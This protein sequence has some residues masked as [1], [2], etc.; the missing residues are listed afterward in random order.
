[1]GIRNFSKTL[2]FVRSNAARDATPSMFHCR[3]SLVNVRF[4]TSA[5]ATAH[6]PSSAERAACACACEETGDWCDGLDDADAD[7]GLDDKDACGRLDEGDDAGLDER[8]A[9]GCA[10]AH[11]SISRKPP[12]MLCVC[13]RLKGLHSVRQSVCHKA[14]E[15]VSSQ[16]SEDA[17]RDRAQRTNP[18]SL[19]LSHSRSSLQSRQKHGA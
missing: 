14:W 4:R 10:A 8:D 9:A 13:A 11:E 3:S 18:L 6:P 1:M 12:M 7:D 2:L 15:K 5:T 16:R 19:S 17:T